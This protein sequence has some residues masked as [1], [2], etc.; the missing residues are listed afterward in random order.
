MS[1]LYVKQ[2]CSQNSET[3]WH[4]LYLQLY[5]KT[6]AMIS[7]II[8]HMFLPFILLCGVREQLIEQ[9]GSHLKHQAQKPYIFHTPISHSPIFSTHRADSKIPP[10]HIPRWVIL[11]LMVIKGN[12]TRHFTS[13]E[14][15]CCLTFS[16]YYPPMKCCF[17]VL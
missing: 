9:Q 6:I 1:W 7:T 10:Y 13:R 11:S 15:M 5:I 4:S 16:Q 3:S 8:F 12:L 14:I 17:A 2:K